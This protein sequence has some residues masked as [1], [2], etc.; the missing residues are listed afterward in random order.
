MIVP[1]ESGIKL[2]APDEEFPNRVPENVTASVMMITYNHAPFIRQSIEGILMQDTDFP[3]ELCIGEDEST[4]STRA[5]C[6]DYAQKHPS[7]IRLFLRSRKDVLYI[8]GFPTGNRNA[9]KTTAACR[10]K[11]VAICEGDDYWTD[12]HKL[13]RQVSFME[14]N[15]NCGLTF[16][17]ANQFWGDADPRN[18]VIAAHYDH[19]EWVP[20]RD[21]ILGGGGFIPS[22]SIVYR[23]SLLNDD[24]TRLISDAPI[25]DIIFQV[26][27]SVRGRARYMNH[28]MST[29]R[30]NAP[31]SWSV[32]NSLGNKRILHTGRVLG[33]WAELAKLIPRDLRIFVFRRMLTISF[34]AGLGSRSV[35]APLAS[36]DCRRVTPTWKSLL[37][38]FSYRF[39][40]A[41]GK[42]H[43]A[44]AGN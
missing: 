5:I 40:R 8:D 30:K 42:I 18:C 14:A 1:N 3:F 24:V 39:G 16:H 37:V 27:M 34:K 41:L 20:P 17:S 29:Y 9:L 12:R 11:Y 26:L 43:A 31:G 21:V 25:G 36:L 6:I 7:K 38:S 13:Q 35:A 28:V 4:D 33:L 2:S 22:S 15:G 19:D 44:L 10:G 32:V 23:R